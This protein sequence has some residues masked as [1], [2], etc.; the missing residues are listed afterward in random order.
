MPHT[1]ALHVVERYRRSGKDTL[2]IKIHIEDPGA[3]SKPWDTRIS[4]RVPR[5]GTK[6]DE[7][8]CENNRNL[9]DA[10]GNTGFQH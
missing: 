1:S 9:P 6:M 2:E 3:F 7:Y 5:A 8:I 10:Q 4:Y